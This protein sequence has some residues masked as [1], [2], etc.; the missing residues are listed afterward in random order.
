MGVDVETFHFM[1][2]QGF[3]TAWD[4]LPI[5]RTDVSQSGHP[6]LVRCSLDA[7]GALG[8]TLHYLNSTMREVSLQQIFA[9]I[10]TTVSHYL[11]FALQILLHT[12]RKIHDA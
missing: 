9:L 6:H 10:P 5:P 1:L 4:S 2:E 3:C 11:S 8:L 12:L 7:A